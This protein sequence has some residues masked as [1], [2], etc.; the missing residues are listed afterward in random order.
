MDNIQKTI[1]IHVPK[2]D[3]YNLISEVENEIEGEL[4]PESR[5]RLLYTGYEIPLLIEINPENGTSKI[6]KIMGKDVSDHGID[7]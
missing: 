6:L 5:E 2:D 1:Y 3:N 7:I 4:L